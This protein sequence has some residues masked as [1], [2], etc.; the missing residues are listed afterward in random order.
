MSLMTWIDERFPLTKMWE[1][2]Y[3][4]FPDHALQAGC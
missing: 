2:H 3:R 1:D 4:Y